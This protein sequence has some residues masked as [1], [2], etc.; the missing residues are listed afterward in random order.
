MGLFR[1]I[2]KEEVHP[3]KDA[4]LVQAKTPQEI[5]KEQLT[6]ELDYLRKELQTKTEH[7]S[8]ISD[9]LAK[10]KSEYDQ[11]VSTLMTSKK[12]LK[13]RKAEHEQ[14]LLQISQTKTHLETINKQIEENKSVLH[15]IQKSKEELQAIKM[16]YEN[17]KEEVE[18]LKPL[19][20]S[21][22]QLKKAHQDALSD[23]EKITREAETK[24]KEIEDAKKELKLIETQMANAANRVAPKNVV[25]AAS[26]VVSSLNSKLLAAQKELETLKIA[27]QRERM[28]HLE[29]KRKLD[30]LQKNQN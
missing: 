28:E 11:L 4:P 9:K 18:K 19:H 22:D 23:L 24:K 2:K 15:E 16:Q 30:E 26:S 3:D 14:L 13:E 17:Y 1:R 10:V 27:L 29:T 7:L 12:D 21:F 5:Q 25:A 8:S 20:E 6:T